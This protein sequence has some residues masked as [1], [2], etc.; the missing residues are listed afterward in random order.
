MCAI[1]GLMAF[2]SSASLVKI[3][4][5]ERMRD[6]MVHRGPDGLGAWISPDGRV[7]LG[8]RRL[9]IIDPSSAAAQPMCNEDGSIW[10]SFNGEIYN[11]AEIRRE[12]EKT[13]H[14]HW[15]T[16]HSDSEVI[17]HA[18][19][20]WGIDCIK[21][22][23]GIFAI[24]LW[25]SRTRELWLIRD[26]LG[27]KP[28]YYSVHHGRLAF[29]SEIKAL[30]EDPEQS[31]ELNQD[32]L[33]HYLSFLTT[34]APQTLFAG[35][36]KLPA[37]HW[38]RVNGDGA[39]EERCY[40]DV[41][42]HTMP[43][44]GMSEGEVSEQIIV[45]LRD[46]ISLR[47]VSDVPVGLFLSG[48]IDSSVNTALFS[49]G[50]L[51]PIKTFSIGYAG[52][53]A[54]YNNELNYAQQM[55]TAIDAKYHERLLTAD[56]L[57]DFLPEM[58]RF[59]D[60][61]NG[62]PVCFPMHFV[63]KLARDNGVKVCQAGEGADELFSGY[64][65]WKTMLRLERCNSWPIPRPLKRLG[66][67]ALTWTGYSDSFR[68][69]WLRRGIAG[70]PIFWGGAEAFT[71]AQKSRLFNPDFR[72]NIA[73]DTSWDALAPIRQRFESAAWDKSDLNWMTYVDLRLRLP[74]LLLM[75][76][77]KMSMGVSLEVRE[78]FLDHKLVEL[79]MSIP[80]HMKLGDGNLKYLLKKSVRG[81]IPDNIID[82]KKQGFG[83]PL[84]EWF[85]GRLGK[86]IRAELES[87]CRET[88]YFDW[89]AVNH[90]IENG[91]PSQ[92]WYL[93]ILALWWRT[94]IAR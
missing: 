41:W 60:E 62:D 87:F 59:Q 89:R 32:A 52:E 72:K 25:D 86:H 24:A 7:G 3:D 36:R 53:Y 23:R 63:S 74:E 37:G 22:F 70:Q 40:W 85:M 84:N 4:L 73:V 2:S 35:I 15:K 6:T 44:I 43:L 31:R 80:T 34:P 64:P 58:V 50:E 51:Q 28:L 81:L 26:R 76:I 94:N 10:L 69:E 33:Y 46:S 17:I 5:I 56:D 77:D 71:E 14:Y 67:S 42:D 92:A 19:E 91:N 30:L 88:D 13:G 75:R 93:Y 68:Y 20:E 66:L 54:S 9:L 39:K 47:K 48:G 45:A 12:L 65:L 61:P 21:R 79:V 49:E 38:L 16:D 83:V 82:R 78:P 18:F 8:H 1:V 55:A 90:L 11:H 57:I 27:V 29:A